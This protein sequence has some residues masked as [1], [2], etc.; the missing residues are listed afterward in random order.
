[1]RWILPHEETK[2]GA[3]PS[4]DRDELIHVPCDVAGGVEPERKPVPT[5]H[6]L[7]RSHLQPLVEQ[8]PSSAL[9]V[10]EFR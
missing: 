6:N 9:G 2:K 5:L 8:F 10:I 3:D 4:L 1:M 7:R